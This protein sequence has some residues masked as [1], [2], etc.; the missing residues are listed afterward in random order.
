MAA[1]EQVE[2]LGGVAG[3]NAFA[4]VELSLYWY[5]LGSGPVAC[6]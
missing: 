5:R 4:G 1:L 6:I 2:D 3:T